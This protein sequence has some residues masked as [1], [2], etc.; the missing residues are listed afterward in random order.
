MPET[1]FERWNKLMKTEA[2]VVK[3]LIYFF[4]FKFTKANTVV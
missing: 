3:V 1:D 2:G 4:L